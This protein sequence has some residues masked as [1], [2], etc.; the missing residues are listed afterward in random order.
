MTRPTHPQG[1]SPAS[2][3]DK[4]AWVL[5]FFCPAFFASNMVMSRAMAGIFPPFAMAFHRWFFVGLIVIIALAL[6]RRLSLTRML[7]EWRSILFLAALGMGL[8]G[9]PVYLAGEYTSATNIGLIYS[10]APLVIALLAYLKFDEAL[11]RRQI[12]GLFLGLIGVVTIIIKGDVSRL[13]SLRF[14][15]G[16]LLIVMA[17]IAFAVY[18]LGLRYIP[19]QLT[20]FERFGAMALGGSLWH[21]PAMLAEISWRGPLPDYTSAIIGAL[22][23]LVFSASLAAY[24]SYGYIVSR[25]GPTIAGATLY[26]SPIYAALG[27]VLLLGEV[28]AP[29]HLVGGGLIL[30]G[31]YLVSQRKSDA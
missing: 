21:I 9:G 3:Q 31:L 22:A 15:E 30:P 12:I 16:D 11:R 8:C 1:G 10:A 6:L 5:L 29:F 26:L 27:G 24:L 14:N 23:I 20:Q 2:F 18:S 28:I 4:L 13:A 17:T 19:T 7:G 25:L